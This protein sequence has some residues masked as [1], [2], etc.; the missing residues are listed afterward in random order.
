MPR[1]WCIGCRAS[2]IKIFIICTSSYYTETRAFKITSKRFF[3]FVG[4]W[5][6]TH[7]R[8][9]TSRVIKFI[10]RKEVWLLQNIV[11]ISRIFFYNHGGEFINMSDNLIGHISISSDKLYEM[12][13]SRFF[14]HGGYQFTIPEL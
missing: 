8:N 1:P 4:V 13:T 12:T 3:Y 11:P 7:L 14:T 5:V 6:D 10:I 9:Y 2:I